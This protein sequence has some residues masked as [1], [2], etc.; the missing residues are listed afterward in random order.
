MQSCGKNRGTRVPSLVPSPAHRLSHT[1]SLSTALA[2]PRVFWPLRFCPSS[3]SLQEK[4]PLWLKIVT[5]KL[6]AL[7]IRDTRKEEECGRRCTY[8]SR[9]CVS[10][11]NDKSCFEKLNYTIIVPDAA[12]LPHPFRIPYLSYLARWGTF[13]G[14]KKSRLPRQ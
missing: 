7:I 2:S 12:S 11:W 6:L 5:E 9:R 10:E 1:P 4:R 14:G 8:R 3:L 13:L